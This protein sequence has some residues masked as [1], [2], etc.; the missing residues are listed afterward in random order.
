MSPDTARSARAAAA[1]EFSL[2]IE[3][4]LAALATTSRQSLAKVAFV[5]RRRSL[6]S[7]V[8]AAATVPS[9]S[10]RSL[11]PMVRSRSIE[12]PVAGSRRDRL[13]KGRG[14]AIS[15]APTAARSH[16]ILSTTVTVTGAAYP[17]RE[18]KR[19]RNVHH[20]PA[21]VLAHPWAE[22]GGVVHPGGGLRPSSL[23]KR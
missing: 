17:D 5:Q 1:T 3:R 10:T 13:K 23:E 21:E 9:P 6:T 19:R 15:V 20:D 16:P 14:A 7:S 2:P 18:G 4:M 11:M 12:A 8:L 22:P